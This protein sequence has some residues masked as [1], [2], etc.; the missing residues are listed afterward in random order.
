MTGI[1]AKCAVYKCAIIIRGQM[2]ERDKPESVIVGKAC[3]F[4][5]SIPWSSR[6]VCGVTFWSRLSSTSLTSNETFLSGIM[7]IKTKWI[8]KITS[9]LGYSYKKYILT[10]WTNIIKLSW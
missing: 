7:L 5:I 3:G 8:I 9:N 6:L 10:N 4:F 2:I 1:W